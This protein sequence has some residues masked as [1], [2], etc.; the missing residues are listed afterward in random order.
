M[1]RHFITGL[2]RSRTAWLAAYFSTGKAFC[3]HEP[4]A[5][6]SS[7]DQIAGL[8]DLPQYDHVGISDSGLGFFTKEI[9]ERFAPRTI[10]VERDPDAVRRSL[11]SIGIPDRF[12]VKVLAEA[13]GS[14]PES[15]LVLRVPF[16]AL[17]DPQVMEQVHRHLV[18][19]VPFDPMRFALMSKLMVECNPAMTVD[20]AYRNRENVAKLMSPVWAKME[21]LEKSHAV[22]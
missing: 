11:Q 2:P 18:P 22:H 12:Y 13:L 6:I 20:E 7:L 3:Y 19:S 9:I 21:K 17:R 4:M 16:D 10:I 5:R 15:P 8:Y 14:V 1:T